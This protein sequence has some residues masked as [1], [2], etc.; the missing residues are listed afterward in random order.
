MVVWL[1]KSEVYLH[2]ALRICACLL[3]T[4]WFWKVVRTY[5]SFNWQHSWKD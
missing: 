1:N 5:C 4:E 2:V 3:L